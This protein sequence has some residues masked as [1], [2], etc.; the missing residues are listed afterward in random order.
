MINLNK[1]NVE[2]FY[3]DYLEGNLNTEDTVMLLS[4]I[5]N[6]PEISN[7]FEDTEGILDYKLE[8]ESLTFGAVDE[9]KSFLGNETICLSTIDFWLIAKTENTLSE[10]QIRKIDSF[11]K[12]NKLE[13]TEAYITAAYLKPDLNEV[14]SEKGILKKKAGII[15]PLFTRVTAIAAIFVF[16]WLTFSQSTTVNPQYSSRDLKK[17]DITVSNYDNS[18]LI[19]HNN[20]IAITNDTHKN[21][22]TIS[23]KK[24]VKSNQ[25]ST[26]GSISSNKETRLTQFFSQPFESIGSSNEI[27]ISPTAQPELINMSHLFA[28]FELALVNRK[29]ADE[30]SENLLAENKLNRHK[31]SQLKEYYK[32]V[33]RT[34]SNLTSLDMSYKKGP[35]SASQSHTLVKIGGFSF[36]RKKKK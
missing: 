6:D 10:N 35:E 22:A 32:P 16:F 1:D 27:L 4:F 25:N 3:L 24:N 9:L 8:A 2:A 7:L 26:G 11:V 14:F 19:R 17:I 12:L 36:E 13:E 30:H 20:E 29:Q 31:S 33:T 18:N 15:L 21:L 5:K 34:L 28:D 23:K